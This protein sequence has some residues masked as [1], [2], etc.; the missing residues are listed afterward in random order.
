DIVVK[1]LRQRLREGSLF[2]GATVQGD[3]R[4]ALILD[5]HAIAARIGAQPVA[6]LAR[7]QEASAPRVAL[8]LVRARRGVPAA[9]RV[10]EVERVVEFEAAAFERLDDHPAVQLDGEAVPLAAFAGDP[11]LGLPGAFDAGRSWPVL[12][13]SRHGRRIGLVVDAVED[14]VDWDGTL[15]HAE[16]GPHRIVLRDRITDLVTLAEVA[17]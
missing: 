17:S 5:V 12:V 14:I 4:V 7:P 8:L 16:S 13:H 15:S 11:S 2:A 3:G 9:V 1:P 10:T 6:E